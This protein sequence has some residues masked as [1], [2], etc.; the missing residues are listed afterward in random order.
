MPECQDELLAEVGRAAAVAVALG[1]PPLAVKT[2]ASNAADFAVQARGA[3]GAAG[4]AMGQVDTGPE[5]DECAR[6]GRVVGQPGVPSCLDCPD[7]TSGRQ[8]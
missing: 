2:A 1:C 7:A 8:E 5:P 6:C 4:R 3:M